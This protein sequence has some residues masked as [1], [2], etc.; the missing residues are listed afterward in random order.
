MTDSGATRLSAGLLD[1]EPGLLDFE[2]LQRLSD[3]ELGFVDFVDREGGM[4]V[5]DRSL[6]HV[7][8]VTRVSH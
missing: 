6:P 5:F 1:G 2:E 7:R 8:R 4:Q 3:V